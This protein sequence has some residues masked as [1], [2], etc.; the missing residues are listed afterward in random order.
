MPNTDYAGKA[1]RYAQSV[2]KRRKPACSL[3]RQACKRHLDNLK[4]SSK[5]TYPYR[6]DKQKANRVCR[7][8]ETLPHVKGRWALAGESIRLEPWQCFTLC[9]VFGWIR[10]AD[11]LRRF[12][13]VYIEVPHPALV[14]GDA[15]ASNEG[16]VG[17]G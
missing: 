10:K 11:K 14:C 9:S 7:F 16:V 15:R 13:I 1:T 2:V 6:F 17:R 8:I 3:V 5:R 12:R 4:Q